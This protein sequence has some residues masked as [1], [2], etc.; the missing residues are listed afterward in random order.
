MEYGLSSRIT[1]LV[2]GFSSSSVF[3]FFCSLIFC[4]Q[5][6]LTVTLNNVPYYRTIGLTDDRTRVRVRIR[7]FGPI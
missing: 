5:T 2:I 6:N 7:I 3:L 4:T 1:G